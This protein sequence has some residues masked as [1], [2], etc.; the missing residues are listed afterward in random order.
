MRKRGHMNPAPLFALAGLAL[1]TT[2]A[3]RNSRGRTRPPGRSNRRFPIHPRL[4]RQP[5]A[6]RRSGRITLKLMVCSSLGPSVGEIGRAVRRQY[7]PSPE[8]PHRRPDPGADPGAAPGRAGKANNTFILRMSTTIG[9]YQNNRADNYNDYNVNGVANLDLGT[10]LRASLSADYLD[11][12][13]PRA[14][15]NSAISST[16]TVTTRPRG[17]AFSPMV[18]R[19]AKGRIDFELGQVRRN[20]YNNLAITA[21]NNRTVD[22]IGATFYWHVGPRTALLFQGKHSKVDYTS[23]ASTLGSVEKRP[24]CGPRPGRRAQRPRARSKSAWW[25]RLSTVPREAAPRRSAGAGK[26]AGAPAPTRSSI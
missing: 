4:R 5:E 16:P 9:Q 24:A 25:K 17:G 6:A 18:A 26:C 14:S 7:L 8:Q 11:G 20:Y 13:D 21:A 15:T 23:S 22:E 1:L 19:D 3:L 12:E 10:R 2:A